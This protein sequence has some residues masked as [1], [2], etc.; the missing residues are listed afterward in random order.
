MR[1]ARPLIQLECG[2]AFKRNLAQVSLVVFIMK[3]RGIGI[4]S[5]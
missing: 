3:V 4:S 2:L 1:I 5:K